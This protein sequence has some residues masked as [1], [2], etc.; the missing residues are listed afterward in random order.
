MDIYKD[1]RTA[2]EMYFEK[3]LKN[4]D[5]SEELDQEL[6]NKV[7]DLIDDIQDLASKTEH[8]IDNEIEDFS[9]ND[10]KRDL[11]DDIRT[12]DEMERGLWLA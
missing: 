2:C 6:W 9:W 3:K 12:Q 1:L 7:I 5:I 4:A 10:Y 11:M 8:E